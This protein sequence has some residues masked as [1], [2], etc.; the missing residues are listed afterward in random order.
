VN[1]EAPFV[2]VGTVVR[3]GASTLPSIEPDDRTAVVRVDRVLRAPQQMEAIAGREITLRLRTRA[4]VGATAVFEAEGW[5]YGESLAVI[6]LRR[7]R[8]PAEPPSATAAAHETESAAAADRAERFRRELK[9][10]ADEASTVVVGRV[11]AVRASPETASATQEFQTEH[12]P[13]W[14][15]AT[16]EVDSAIKGRAPR[17]VEVLFATSRDVMWENAPKLAVGQQAV[18]LLQ[19]GVPDVPDS[20]ANVV[21]HPLDVRPADT[22]GF[23][24]ELL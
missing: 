17:T 23:V 7:R 18:M 3:T 6:E 14:A 2:F 1:D 20:K 8:A 4:D 12:D 5:R 16:V 11:V 15:V 13:Q 19:K 9:V 22:A 21:L 24:E 10:R